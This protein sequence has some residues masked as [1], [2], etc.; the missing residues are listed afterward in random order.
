MFWAV[1]PTSTSISR[2][3]CAPDAQVSE[4]YQA[5]R[6]CFTSSGNRYFLSHTAPKRKFQTQVL[7]NRLHHRK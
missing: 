5:L 7:D 4:L 3:W 1:F 6:T 2:T